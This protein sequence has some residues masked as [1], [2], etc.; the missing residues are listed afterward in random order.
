MGIFR[1]FSGFNPPKWIRCRYKSL[2]N[3]SDIVSKILCYKPY[4]LWCLGVLTPK[5][6]SCGVCA[7]KSINLH[8]TIKFIYI[9]RKQLAMLRFIGQAS[10]FHKFYLVNVLKIRYNYWR[11]SKFNP[12]TLTLSILRLRIICWFQGLLR[13]YNGK[14]RGVLIFRNAFYGQLESLNYCPAYSTRAL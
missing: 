3:W 1:W 11:S 14:A 5:L 9:H 10:N 13:T 7:L 4:C 8:I 6:S 2:K 12:V